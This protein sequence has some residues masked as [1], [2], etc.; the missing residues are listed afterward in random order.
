[1]PTPAQTFGRNLRRLRTERDF[2]QESLAHAAGLNMTHVARIERGERE[3]G[4]VVIAKLAGTLDVQVDD[5]FAG[6]VKA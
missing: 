1:V 6:V 3:P 5:L 2:T 4:L